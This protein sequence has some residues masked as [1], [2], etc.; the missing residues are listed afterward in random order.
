MCVSVCVWILFFHICLTFLA[1]KT[2]LELAIQPNICI[3]IYKRIR[4]PI[5]TYEIKYLKLDEIHGNVIQ[6]V[7]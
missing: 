6:S 4:C 7:C 2:F 3:D 1:V 5:H